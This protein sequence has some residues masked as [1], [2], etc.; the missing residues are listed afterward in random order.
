M[1]KFLRNRRAKKRAA[2]QEV[3]DRVINYNSTASLQRELGLDR[4]VI[5]FRPAGKKMGFT[6]ERIYIEVNDKRYLSE[7]YAMPMSRSWCYNGSNYEER[8][9]VDEEWLENSSRPYEFR[10][11]YYKLTG[12]VLSNGY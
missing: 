10:K 3:I 4:L 12:K 7:P 5:E 8:L 6:L 1:I 11:G 9:V 2:A